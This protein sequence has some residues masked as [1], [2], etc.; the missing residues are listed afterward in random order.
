M[1]DIIRKNNFGQLSYCRDCQLFNLTFSNILIELTER[2]LIA[3]HMIV[4]EI[5]I[6]YW[7]NHPNSQTHRRK[8]PINTN[9]KN[10]V[11]IFDFFEL[12]ALKELV[13]IIV[14]NKKKYISYNEIDNQIN[15]N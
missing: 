14:S 1:N 2:E 9:Q 11:L 3:F 13:L 15:F 4:K 10:L 8:F 12:K 6:D 5:N 7:N